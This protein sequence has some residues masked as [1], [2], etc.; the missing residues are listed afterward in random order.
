MTAVSKP[1][2]SGDAPASDA[3]EAAERRSPAIETLRVPTGITRVVKALLDASEA[4]VVLE[5]EHGFWRGSEPG[6][7]LDASDPAARMAQEVGDFLWVEDL[8]QDHRFKTHPMVAGPPYYRFYAGAS[9]LGEDGAKL[10][11]LVAYGDQPR[12]LNEGQIAW[13]RDMAE[14]FGVEYHHRK[15]ARD[16]IEILERVAQ[17]EQRL[18][19]AIESAKLN[20]YEVDY[21]SESMLK[22][23]TED[24]IF[25]RPL[26]YE[27]VKYTLSNVLPEDRPLVRAAWA[28]HMETGEPYCCEYRVNRSDGQE[29]WVSST[30]ELF[31]DADG[32]PLRL[33]G[34]LQ[35]ITARKQAET[36]MVEAV[37]QAEAANVAKSAFLATMSHE[38]RTP[39]NG[40]LGMAQAMAADNLDPVQRERLDVIRQSGESLLAILNDILDLSKIEAGKLN[41][42]EIEFDLGEIALGA[43]AAFTTLANKKGVSFDLNMDEAAGVYRG[44]PTRLRQILY[45]LVSNALKFT[46]TG[47]IRVKMTRVPNGLSL[48]VSD[49]GIGMSPDVVSNLFTKFGQADAST[50]R[51]YGGTGL[52]LAIC[53]QLSEMMG[54]EILVTSTPGAGSTFTVLLPMVWIS[55]PVAAAAHTMQETD[56]DD[57]EGV[58][59]RVLAAEDNPI[60]QLVLKTLLHQAGIDPVVVN[61]GAEALAAWKAGAFDLILMD[62]QMPVMDGPSATRAIRK[63]EAETGRSPIPIIALTANAMSHQIAEYL[64]SG[65]DGH[66]AKPIE[67]AKLFAVLEMAAERMMEAQAQVAAA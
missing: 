29:V 34:A 12:P 41:L 18:K 7:V 26:T 49:T 39:L 33:V 42:E 60:N 52:G 44:D 48:T 46:D 61:N 57:G 65:M 9:I 58:E 24:T 47:E 55:G 67:A 31:T 3:R 19:I 63:A 62:V 14:I 64:A 54:G 25:E 11:V 59:L 51:K 4:D 50:T 5:L 30:S 20:V 43:H 17:S 6:K 16:R 1:I 45:N 53:R 27:D 23:G 22:M 15:A 56:E 13:L 2:V 35:N 40:V 21:V 36:A 37:K 10:G 8:T 32:K 38:I 66:V 28:R